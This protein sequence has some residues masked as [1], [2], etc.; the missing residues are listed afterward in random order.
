MRHRW[1][2]AAD[3]WH[4]DDSCRPRVWRARDAA[5]IRAATRW[6][7]TLRPI[8]RRRCAA[9]P[10]CIAAYATT[11]RHPAGTARRPVVRDTSGTR[12]C[13]MAVGVPAGVDTLRRRHP[14]AER[15]G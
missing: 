9:R 5:V 15:L 10:G 12:Y 7:R 11:R 8:R 3:Y 1:P 6:Y 14:T 13:G 4:H 2:A